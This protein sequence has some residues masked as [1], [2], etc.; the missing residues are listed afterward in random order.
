MSEPQE[1]PS[2]TPRR[3]SLWEIAWGFNQISIYS[4]GG[5]LSAWSR[6]VVVE[7]KQWM[8]D[9]EFL[10]ALTLCRI[11]PGA[12]QVNLA[13]YVGTRLRGAPGSVAAV[14]GLTLIPAIIA[15]T[16][17]FFYFRYH[18]VP[19][20]QDVLR[21]MAAAATGL[22]L[23]MGLKTGGKFLKDPIALVFGVLAFIGAG[24]LHWPL[25][26]VLAMLAPP[27][28]LHSLKKKPA[29]ANSASEKTGKP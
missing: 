26:G 4:F 18:T 6:R 7:D 14:V 24:L 27:A 21:G 25:L 1:A 20:M 23:S 15:T 5:G 16:L 2:S 3:I 22:A 19:Q 12:N 29:G 13:V 28:I 9:E 8:T 11:M 17:G 10:S